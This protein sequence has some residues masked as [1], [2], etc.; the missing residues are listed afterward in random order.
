VVKGKPKKKKEKQK[1][2]TYCLLAW[3]FMGMISTLHSTSVML[4]PFP[5][6]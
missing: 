4:A 5:S 2:N 1:E 3:A 6:F